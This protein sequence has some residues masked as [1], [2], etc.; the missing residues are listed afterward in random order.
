MPAVNDPL[1]SPEWPRVITGGLPVDLVD[2]DRAL[3]VISHYAEGRTAGSLALISANLDHIHHFGQDSTWLQRT[4]ASL[5]AGLTSNGSPGMHW[6]TL[7]DGV[8]LARTAERITGTPWPRLSGSD[9]IDPVLDLAAASGWRVGFLGGSRDTQAA[10]REAMRLRRPGLVVSGYWAPPREE[11]FD[12]P[13]AHRL[14]AEIA[15]ADTTILVVGLGKPR[16]ER[17]IEQFGPFTEARVLLAFGAV[18]DFLAGRVRR[19]PT[20][21][22]DRGLEWAWRLS[23]EPKRLARRYLVQGPGAYLRLRRQSRLPTSGRPKAGTLTSIERDQ[24]VS[25]SLHTFAQIGE[26]AVVTA[27]IVTYNSRNDIDSLITSLRAEAASLSIRVIVCDNGSTDD[28]VRELRQHPDILVLDTGQNSG[29]AAGINLAVRHNSGSDAILILNPDIV[30]T[31]GSLA[32]MLDRL[33]SAGAGAVVPLILDEEGRVFPSIRHE[34]SVLGTIGDSL[35]GHRLPR[36]PRSLSEIDFRIDEYYRPRS[37]AWATGAA[38]LLCSKVAKAVGDWDEG[39]FLYSE[40]TDYFRRIRDLGYSVWFE[41]KAVVSHRGAGS[42]SS[43]ELNVLMTVNKAVYAEKYMPRIRA[44]LFRVALILGELL[45]SAD[46]THRQTYRALAQRLS[47]AEASAHLRRPSV[48]LDPGFC[49]GSVV[50]PAHN[51]QSVILRL[52]QPLSPFAKG[53][54]I[55]IVV[56]CN[57]CTDNTAAIARSVPGVRVVEIAGASKVAALNEGDRAATSWPRMYLDADVECPADTVFAVLDS[58]SNG[59]FLA[60]RPTAHYSTGDA[61][62]LVRSYYRARQRM[63]VGEDALWGAGAYAVSQSGH[64]RFDHFPQFTGDDLFIDGQFGEG[65]KIVL[66]TSPVIVH[67][68]RTSRALLA[69]LRRS[70]SGNSAYFSSDVGHRGRNADSGRETLLALIRSV[71]GPRSAGDA[72]VYA[73]Y[74]IISRTLIRIESR[75]GHDQWLRDES[76]RKSTTA[77]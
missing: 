26:R 38:V 46:P 77:I 59:N 63:R 71:R 18:V 47:S 3:Q 5:S 13:A 49:H 51:E 29:Y 57:G 17:W 64:G 28:T 58:L 45:R 31:P 41:P 56:I 22:S 32:K 61:S 42:G 50:V 16:Q 72:A 21:I 27:I 1:T 69:I 73:A 68:P 34:P 19:A 54:N 48:H 25:P 36:R 66:P 52:L 43:P 53:G 74:A 75:S 12:R 35:F 70:N 20:W 15:A 4:P 60:A 10:L 23:R 40:E 76:S 14:A 44:S 2:R 24:E 7:I 9:M 55:E 39:Y 37:I 8:P 6:M 30:I 11:L 62:P 67:T 65:E 33:H